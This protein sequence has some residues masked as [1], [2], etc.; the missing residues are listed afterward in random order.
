MNLLWGPDGF[1]IA[2]ARPDGRRTMALLHEAGAR[3]PVLV[4]P[5]VS[6]V[7]AREVVRLELSDFL[8]VLESHTLRLA[9]EGRLGDN[10]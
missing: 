5:V 4:Q 2:V 9:Q 6:P 1:V 7:G 8:D 3:R 10:E